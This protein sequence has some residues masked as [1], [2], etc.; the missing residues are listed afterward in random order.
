M[1]AVH[2]DWQLFVNGQLSATAKLYLKLPVRSMYA[3]VIH[4]PIDP[5]YRNWAYA[6]VNHTTSVPVS[7]DSM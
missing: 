7:I 1:F 2:R 3:L 6:I 4:E 5:T